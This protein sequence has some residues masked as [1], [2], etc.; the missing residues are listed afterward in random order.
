MFSVYKMN[1]LSVPTYVLSDMIQ[2]IDDIGLA[3]KF[4]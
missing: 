1:S 2:N 3:K 4:I